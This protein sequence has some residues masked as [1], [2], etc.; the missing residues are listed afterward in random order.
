[1]RP[2]GTTTSTAARI[3]TLYTSI[4]RFSDMRALS[5]SRAVNTRMTIWGITGMAVAQIRK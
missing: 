2:T 4:D 3:I 5:A 1:M